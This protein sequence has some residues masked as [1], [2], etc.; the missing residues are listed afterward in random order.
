VDARFLRA[1]AGLIASA[2]ESE[3]A[4]FDRGRLAGF[5]DGWRAGLLAGAVRR[6]AA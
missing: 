3:G 2:G 5:A 6:T 4:A 1:T